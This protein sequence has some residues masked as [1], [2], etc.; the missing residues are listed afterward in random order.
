MLKENATPASSFCQ[1]PVLKVKCQGV[2]FSLLDPN[3]Y[4]DM[5]VLET[6][7]TIFVGGRKGTVKCG[8]KYSVLSVD[9]YGKK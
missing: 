2:E 7:N 4:T 8:L 1:N 9:L 3:I 6:E 5:F